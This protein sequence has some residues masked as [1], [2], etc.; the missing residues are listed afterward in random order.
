MSKNSRRHIHITLD[1]KD[2]LKRLEELCKKG[3]YYYQ[4]E[5]E[6][7]GNGVMMECSLNHIRGRNLLYKE[8]KFIKNCKTINE[9][10]KIISDI[11]LN[12]IGLGTS[13]SDEY[14]QED[15]ILFHGE[16]KKKED[17]KPTGLDFLMKMVKTA[18]CQEFKF[19]KDNFSKN[20]EHILEEVLKELEEDENL[21][22]IFKLLNP[23]S[24]C[25]KTSSTTEP[26]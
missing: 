3:G 7:F 14:V 6:L 22:N 1:E 2:P 19:D 10:K 18:G 12:N 24:S 25:T 21:T 11:L 16:E 20:S 5:W 9:G 15:E 13:S 23:Q 4:M 17:Q 8:V 26:K